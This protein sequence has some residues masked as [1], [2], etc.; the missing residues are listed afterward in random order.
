MM[1]ERTLCSL[2]I[3]WGR[4]LLGV[5]GGVIGLAAYPADGDVGTS[6]P[7][8]ASR[9]RGARRRDAVHP[10]WRRLQDGWEQPGFW[11]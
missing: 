9:R 3:A 1:I 4:F 2:R 11:F 8:R 10:A 5:S 6:L 7:S